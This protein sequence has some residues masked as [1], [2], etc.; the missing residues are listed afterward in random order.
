MQNYCKIT[1]MRTVEGVEE[2]PYISITFEV[3]VEADFIITLCS[4]PHH[5]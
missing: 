1:P 3:C 2:H 4:M 5:V